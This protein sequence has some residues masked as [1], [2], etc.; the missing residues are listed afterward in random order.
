M[1]E[2]GTRHFPG[3]HGLG[4]RIGLLVFVGL[5]CGLVSAVPAYRF[6]PGEVIWWWIRPGHLVLMA[7]PLA[8]AVSVVFELLKARRPDHR[9]P[10]AARVA[11][12]AGAFLVGAV[13]LSG[14]VLLLLQVPGE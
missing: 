14:L 6:G 13:F 5:V 4:S 11:E 10:L 9:L 1:S 7:G 8:A 3:R 12:L 2:S